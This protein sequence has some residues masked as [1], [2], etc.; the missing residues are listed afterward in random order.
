VD[1]EGLLWQSVVDADGHEGWV[2]ADYL[3]Y[4]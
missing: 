3:L 4:R 2:A 1:V